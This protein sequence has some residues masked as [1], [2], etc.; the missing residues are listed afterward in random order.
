MAK[1]TRLTDHD[2]ELVSAAVSAA[3]TRSAGEI[4]TIVSD[5]SHTYADV[6][7]LWSVLAAFLALIALAMAPNFYL[8]LYDRLTGGWAQQWSP[9]QLFELAAGVAMLKFT[10]AWLLL[11]WRPLRLLLVPHPFKH[12]RV[13][14]R[15]VTLFH[16]AAD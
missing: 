2:R 15:A 16:A 9:H 11:L 4:V 14:E 13:R 12:S 8:G 3:E 6:A 5:H 1:V 7:L 10:G